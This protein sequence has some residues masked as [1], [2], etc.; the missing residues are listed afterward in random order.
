MKILNNLFEV[1]N[2]FITDTGFSSGIK[3]NPEHLVYSGHFPGHPVTPGVIQMYI[4]HN[5]LET[6]FQKRIKLLSISQCKFLKILNPL[7]NSE[8][9]V[10]VIIKNYGEVLTIN[11]TGETHTAVFLKLNANYQFV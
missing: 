8:L 2:Y 3:L 4:V 6:H 10:T 7:E 11:A 9:N 5:L 1:V